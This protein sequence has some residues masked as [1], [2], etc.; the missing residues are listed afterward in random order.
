M[1]EHNI[2][3]QVLFSPVNAGADTLLIL[4]AYATPNMASW[5]IKNLQERNLGQISIKLIVGMTPY[6]G[7]SLDVHKGFI[8][9][10][11]N[12]YPEQSAFSCSY[13]Y[14]NPPV[15]SNLYL[16][17]K[18]SFPMAAF[19]G[20]MEFLQSSFVSGRCELAEECNPQDALV[21]FNSAE[22]RSIYCD[23]NDIEEY[24][25]IKNKHPILDEESDPRGQL[26]G[27]GITQVT[28]PLLS[29]SGDT[30][31][32]SG[33]N[34]GHRNKRNRNEA[35]IPLPARIAKSGFFPLG[36]KH[37]TAWTDD[38]HN[39]I[40]R[41]EQA[42]NKAITTPMSNALLGEYF[43]GRIERANGAYVS[44]QDL[45]VYGRTDVTFYKIDDEEYYM[46]FSVA[47]EAQMN[48][49]G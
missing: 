3:Q 10:K 21:Y 16:W 33:L 5:L 2:A 6:N 9:L 29:R 15:H 31:K 7:I 41:V 4:S 11:H 8:E 26:S 18:E 46:D 30:G 19:T 45:E 42:N 32:K 35:Y 1:I 28:L 14:E 22:A 43:R 13:V 20:S 44:L 34:W 36:K 17:L 37:F 48:A 39:L 24:I 49:N 23:S 25:I 47:K 27:E 40:L 38:G 12:C